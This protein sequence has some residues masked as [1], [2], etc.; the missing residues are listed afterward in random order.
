MQLKKFLGFVLLLCVDGKLLHK[1]ISVSKPSLKLF[2]VVKFHNDVCTT[3]SGRNGTC[4]TSEECANHGGAADGSCAQGFGVCC[5]FEAACGSTVNI[6]GTYLALNITEDSSECKVAVCPRDNDVCRVRLD[7]ESF[8]LAGP[9][10]DTAA[11]V[12]DTAVKNRHSIVGECLEDLFVVTSAEGPSPPVICGENTGQ[13]MYTSVRDGCAQIYVK[14]GV[15]TVQRSISIKTTQ[16]A[17]KAEPLTDCLQWFTGVS[18]V[19]QSFNDG[20]TGTHL[21][22][23][24]YTSCVRRERGYCSICW[25]STQFQ[26]SLQTADNGVT[27]NKATSEHDIDCGRAFISD[28]TN[29]PTYAGFADFIEIPQGR[30]VGATDDTDSID[31]YCGEILACSATA[32]GTAS[33]VPS[34]VCS[35]VY[36]FQ[37]RVYTDAFEEISMEDG[38][39]GSTT[40]TRSPQTGF[41]ISYT[42]Q[43]CS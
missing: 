27:G 40:S 5:L 16:I 2:T 20:G 23:Q 36:P 39:P 38:V 19:I 33:T 22:N 34:T 31:R 10:Q 13:H 26:L 3:D 24:Q 32:T 35:S 18:G 41:S 9:F 43:P 7:F 15:S 14:T 42:Q 21:T 1:Q 17:C 11:D 30:C 4:Y 6:N 25:S 29:M 12:V 28:D 8:T 37:L